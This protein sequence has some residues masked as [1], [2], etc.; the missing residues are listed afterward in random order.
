M[1][2]LANI[3]D[4]ELNSHT[5]SIKELVIQAVRHKREALTN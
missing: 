2:L 3:L 4:R 5:E 1:D